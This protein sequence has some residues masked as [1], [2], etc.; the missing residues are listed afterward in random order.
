M[1]ETFNILGGPK[2]LDAFYASFKGEK[3]EGKGNKLTVRT[4]ELNTSSRK[5]PHAYVQITGLEWEDGGRNNINFKGLLKFG[6]QTLNV[7]GFYVLTK[8]TGTMKLDV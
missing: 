5:I 2:E 7:T 6:E 4:V 3:S 1:A 8:Q